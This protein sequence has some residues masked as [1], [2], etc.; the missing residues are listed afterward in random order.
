MRTNALDEPTCC[1]G[2]QVEAV[3]SRRRIKERNS[4]SASVALH[5]CTSRMAGVGRRGLRLHV[6]VAFTL[7]LSAWVSRSTCSS[8]H[9]LGENPQH[10]GVDEATAAG[11]ERGKILFD[12]KDLELQ[13]EPSSA[14]ASGKLL[15][16]ILGQSSRS[17]KLPFFSCR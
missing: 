1:Q 17:G 5:R 4:S 14:A 6:T 11:E 8:L 3:E 2:T 9:R 7:V 12:G 15:K 16:I 13:V 10:T